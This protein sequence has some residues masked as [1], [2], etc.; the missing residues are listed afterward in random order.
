MLH[1]AV[2]VAIVVEVA[3][4]DVVFA[5][6]D[7]DAPDA[8]VVVVVDASIAVVDD[9]VSPSS[10]AFAL[11]ALATTATRATIVD[12]SF[13]V[14]FVVADDVVA[15]AIVDILIHYLV[16]ALCICRPC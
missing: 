4:A 16:S 6:A 7:D 11:P 5:D 12:A 10:F 3:L 8:I 14:V 9:V 15:A 2:V 13:V 1:F